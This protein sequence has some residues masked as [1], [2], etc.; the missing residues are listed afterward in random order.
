MVIV[1]L[2]YHIKTSIHPLSIFS[3]LAHNLMINVV[4]NSIFFLWLLTTIHRFSRTHGPSAFHRLL[5][6]RQPYLTTH[7]RGNVPPVTNEVFC[8]TR[9]DDK[10]VEQKRSTSIRANSDS[11]S[12]DMDE[13]N[14][15][16]E[17]Q[18]KQR[19]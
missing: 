16:Y 8:G 3:L 15:Q 19:I 12:N 7:L 10:D 9:T 18:Y 6:L 1:S 13:S 17:K 4:L 5:H 14:S 2:L 11:V